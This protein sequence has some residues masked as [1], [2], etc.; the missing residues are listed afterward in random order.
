METKD[1]IDKA[2]VAASVAE[3]AGFAETAA[4]FQRLAENLLWELMSQREEMAA[5]QR[6]RHHNFNFLSCQT[7]C[8]TSH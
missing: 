6:Q 8:P 3:S 5:I 1:L 4:A 7:P 2:L